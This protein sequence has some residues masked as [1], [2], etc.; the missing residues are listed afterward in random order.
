MNFYPQGKSLADVSQY[1]YICCTF[2]SSKSDKIK[3]GKNQNSGA[4]GNLIEV[5]QEG[6][7]R[8]SDTKKHLRVKISTEK[9]S[10]EQQDQQSSLTEK[11]TERKS[12]DLSSLDSSLD[13]DQQRNLQQTEKLIRAKSAPVVT[14][15]ELNELL[16]E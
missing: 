6:S 12:L 5:E 3:E 8:S 4:E 16:W 2:S 15:D 11:P 1:F 10:P 7:S 13:S 14:L 9:N